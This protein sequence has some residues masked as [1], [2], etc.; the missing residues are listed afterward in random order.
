MRLA[1]GEYLGTV[2]ANS[3]MEEVQILIQRLEKN[4]GRLW[5]QPRDSPIHKICVHQAELVQV[6]RGWIEDIVIDASQ[7][8]SWA[9]RMSSSKYVGTFG[10]SG[11]IGSEEFV[12]HTVI[13]EES[14]CGIKVQL[15]ISL[16]PIHEEVDRERRLCIGSEGTR[17]DEGKS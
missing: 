17:S 3:T 15:V 1:I 11:T 2:V 7:I 16:T 4:T 10:A 6:C 5:I 9:D 8:R 14:T 13:F 12:W